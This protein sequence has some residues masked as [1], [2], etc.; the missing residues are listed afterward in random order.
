[1]YYLVVLIIYMESV[2]HILGF[3]PKP[4]SIKGYLLY[5]FVIYLI[6]FLIGSI[7]SSVHKETPKGINPI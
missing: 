5:A 2:K 7:F 1:M 4:F 3:L 6:I